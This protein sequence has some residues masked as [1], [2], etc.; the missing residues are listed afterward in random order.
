MI[1]LTQKKYFIFDLDGTL[2]DLEQLN[3]TSFK[4][5]IKS[6]T[7]L[8]LAYDEY[9]HLFAG[10]GSKRGVERYIELKS[11]K[12][13]DP[14]SITSAY[15]AKKEIVLTNSFHENV[16]VKPGLELYLQKLKDTGRLLAVG[17]S[18]G[19]RFAKMILDKANLTSYFDVI[20]TLD[21]VEVTKPAPDIFLEALSRMNGSKEEA[22]IFEDTINGRDAAKN[23]GIEYII[24]YTQGTSEPTLQ[25]EEHIINSYLM[26]KV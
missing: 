9:L 3:F 10:S 5:A 23:A 11:L 19:G 2:V 16:T 17:T 12:N 18:T 6:V 26:L 22:V 15:R 24:V 13:V 20:V 14:K 1:D 25:D 4:E 7:G 21:E 8:T